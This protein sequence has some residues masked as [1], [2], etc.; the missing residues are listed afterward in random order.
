MAQGFGAFVSPGPLAQDHAH[1]EGL[2]QCTQCHEPGSGVTAGRC[3]ACHED[4]GEQIAEKRGFHGD[5]TA[6]ATCHPDHRGRDFVMVQL[7]RDDFDHDVTGFPLEGGHEDVECADC[8]TDEDVWTGLDPTCVACHRD[9]EP[10]GASDGRTEQILQCESCHGVVAWDVVRIGGRRFD[11][12]DP[13]QA[14]FALVGKHAEVECLDCHEEALFVPVASEACTDCHESVHR[15]AALRAPCENCH[16]PEGWRM[17][18]FDHALTGYLLAG[19]HA[20]VA[21]SEC[22]GRSRIAPVGHE[23]C[24]SC[25]TDIHSGQFVPRT[26]DGCHTVEVAAFRIPDFDHSA[27]DYPLRGAH[28]PVACADCHGPLPDSTFAG[29]PFDDCDSCHEDAHDGHFEPTLCLTCHDEGSGGWEVQDFDHDRTPFPLVGQH[30]DV[31]CEGC[32]PNEQWQVPF[33]SCSDCHD[34]HP[35][36]SASPG[37]CASCHGPEGWT[38]S[39]FDHRDTGFLLDG[40]HEGVD[41]VDCHDL[42]AFVEVGTTCG[43]CHTPPAR[44]YEGRCDGCHSGTAWSPATLGGQSHEITGFALEGAHGRL[45]CLSC[46]PDGQRA[47]QAQSTCISCHADDDIHRHLLGDSC[48]DCHAPTSWIR[49]RY[50]HQQTGWPLRGAHRLAACVDCHAIRYIGTPTDC[51]RCHE[52][53]APRSIAAH[54]SPFFSQCDSCHRPFTWDVVR[55]IH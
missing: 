53:E 5:K 28:E 30:V 49:T 25:H 47:S 43:D 11:H 8:H 41:C 24:E 29:L 33:E 17:S 1:I 50:R 34:E 14:D 51:W 46:H 2:T 15:A 13:G 52:T 36:G 39:L 55:G 3:T 42:E 12:D 54:Q 38:P 32:H 20:D 35:H 19:M 22:H 10:H 26:C 4:V 48:Q 23:T 21:C 16:N 45:D 44:H 6:C 9:D 31:A 27:T 37:V 7:D 40:G 18:G